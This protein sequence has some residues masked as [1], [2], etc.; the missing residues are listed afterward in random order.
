MTFSLSVNA[1]EARYIRL[2]NALI[3]TPDKPTLL[4]SKQSVESPVS[5]LYLVQFSHPYREEWRA[6]LE[7]AGVSLLRYVPENAFV[8]R[9]RESQLSR[10]RVLDYVRWVGE[11][12][13]EYRLQRSLDASSGWMVGANRLPVKLLLTPD[14]GEVEVLSLQEGLG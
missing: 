10:V 5:G 11:Y 4:A 3:S 8:A 12:R 14:A 1:Q 2:R 6:A 9:F 13:P 7:Q